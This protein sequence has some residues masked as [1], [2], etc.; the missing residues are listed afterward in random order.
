VTQPTFAVS[1]DTSLAR[2]AFVANFEE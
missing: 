1:F 2:L